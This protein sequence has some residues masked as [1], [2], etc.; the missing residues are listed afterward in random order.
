MKKLNLLLFLFLT[1]I[2]SAVSEIRV[3]ITWDF[4]SQLLLDEKL[5]L[6][7]RTSALEALKQVAQVETAYGGGFVKG[8]NGT[9]S[10]FMGAASSKKD[11]FVFINGI[12]ANTGALDYTL[13]PG[14]IEQWDFH[15]WTFQRSVPAITGGFP[16]PFAGGFAGRTRPACIQ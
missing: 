10:E 15:T 8:I 11:W 2:L 7:G 4:G 3:V 1:L 6:T 12:L 16:Q 5:V 13:Q 9:R 14:D